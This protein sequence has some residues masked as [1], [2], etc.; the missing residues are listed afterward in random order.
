MS[1]AGNMNHQQFIAPDPPAKLGIKYCQEIVY[2]SYPEV[3]QGNKHNSN[4]A[5]L[6]FHLIDEDFVPD[7]QISSAASIPISCLQKGLLLVDSFVQL[8]QY[9]SWSSF[10]ES[11]VFSIPK[12]NIEEFPSA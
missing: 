2:Q 7:N 11:L 12:S 4:V 6:V 3:G 8:K 10:K 9:K 1:P 5:M